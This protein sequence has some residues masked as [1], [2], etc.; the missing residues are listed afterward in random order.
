MP[1][2]PT[3]TFDNTVA[4][5]QHENAELRRRLEISEE[6]MRALR[7]GEVDAITI[8]TPEGVK[9]FALKGADQPYRVMVESMSE[10]AVTVGA[11]G[12]IL[13]GNRRFAEMIKSNLDAIFGSSL[14]THFTDADRDRIVAALHENHDITRLTTD[15]VGVDGTLIPVNIAI[16]ILNDEIG[17]YVVIIS[18]MTQMVAAQ[19][20][21]AD[22]TTLL[23][24]ILQS[25][26]KYSIIGVA[27]DG[28]I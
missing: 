19:S 17:R 23:N 9:I 10:G 1:N 28:K 13:Y 20:K 2:D 12:M 3:M 21:I 4:G 26:I 25:S 24:N 15:L 14:P 8:E 11:D 16:R 27:L 18:D 7:A 5:L 6:P 22:T